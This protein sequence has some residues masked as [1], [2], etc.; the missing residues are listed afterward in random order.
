MWNVRGINDPNKRAHI[1]HQID[2][3]GVDIV[4]L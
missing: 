1:K 2:A 3:S 4:L